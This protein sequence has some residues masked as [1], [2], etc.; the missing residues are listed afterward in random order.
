MF[1]KFLLQLKVLMARLPI[2]GS[3]EDAWGEILNE[4]L[5]VSHTS[6]GDIKQDAVGANQIQDGSITSAQ[7]A[8]G[9]I[10]NVDISGSAAISQ[11]KIANLSSDLSGK[12]PLDADLTAIAGLAPANDDL[13]QRKS[14]AWTNRTPA[15][16]KTDLSLAKTD[17]GLG[18]VD[19]TSDAN[20]PISTATQTA[21]DGKVAKD[22]TVTSNPSAPLVVHRRQFGVQSSDQDI[23]QFYAGTTP[24]LTG[25]INEW[26]G[27][28]GMPYFNWDAVVRV[29][30]HATQT[31]NIIEYQNNARDTTLWGIDKDGYTVM[32]SVKMAPVLV[33]GAADP[34]PANTPVGTVIIR[35]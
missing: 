12:Q 29:V 24:T 9:T 3:D 17:V 22:S 23:M 14:G 16:L 1:S 7:I 4:Y 15:Q 10:V 6:S 21:L 2:P 33:L 13:I 32:K 35:T 5:D 18:N 25:W 19:N 27:Y 28:R 20:K 34:V 8:D 26:G 11:S 31:G 30:A